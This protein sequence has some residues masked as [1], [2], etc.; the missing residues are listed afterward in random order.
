M[1]D[2]AGAKTD[3]MGPISTQPQDDIGINDSAPVRFGSGSQTKNRQRI[4]DCEQHKLSISFY[5]LKII[6]LLGC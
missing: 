2:L 5:F 3:K 4:Q 6:F 1:Y